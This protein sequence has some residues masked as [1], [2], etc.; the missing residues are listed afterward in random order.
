[1]ITPGN[2]AGGNVNSPSD[3]VTRRRRHRC[4]GDTDRKADEDDSD[5]KMWSSTH[6]TC[7]LIRSWALVKTA[8]VGTGDGSP[9]PSGCSTPVRDPCGQ[10]EI[11]DYVSGGFTFNA[12]LNPGTVTACGASSNDAG[13]KAQA[14][15]RQAVFPGRPLRS[16]HHP[17]VNGGLSSGHAGE[18]G[19]D[20][21]GYGTS[22][23]CR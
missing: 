12:G 20:Q 13:G 16:R 5:R 15:C 7:A 22:R 11:T 1:M 2:D 17:T 8:M 14:N 19:G 18:H 10:C 3:D 6:S 21:L 23:A 9:S 4:P